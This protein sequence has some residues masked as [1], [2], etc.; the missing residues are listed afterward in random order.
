MNYV[1]FDIE[2]A[3]C[4]HGEGKICSFGFVKTDENFNV[5]QEHDL[6]RN[7]DAPFLLG[8]AKT[9]K[10]ITLAYPLDRKSV[11]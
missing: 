3:N 6:L 7:P 10:G 1:F 11:V 5:I 4:I 9:G 2:C 8:N